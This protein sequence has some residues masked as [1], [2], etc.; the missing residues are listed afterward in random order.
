MH[1]VPQPF[2]SFF[3]NPLHIL[4]PIHYPLDENK[5]KISIEHPKQK[6]RLLPRCCG[7]GVFVPLVEGKLPLPGSR[8]IGRN[9]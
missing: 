4:G 1:S 6:S 7:D 2:L 8:Q 3:G 9:Q 5:K